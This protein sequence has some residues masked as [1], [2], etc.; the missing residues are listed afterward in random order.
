MSTE[1]A[2]HLAPELLHAGINDIKELS[3]SRVISG[4]GGAIDGCRAGSWAGVGVVTAL[5]VRLVAARRGI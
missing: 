5:A 1:F 4:R 2:A 3:D